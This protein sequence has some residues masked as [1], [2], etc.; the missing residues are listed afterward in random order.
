MKRNKIL[1]SMLICSLV[2]GSVT[3]CGSAARNNGEAESKGGKVKLTA[4]VNKHSLTKDLDEMEWLKE[5][6]EKA[7]VEIEWQQISADWDQKKSAMFASGEIPDLLFNATADA[8]YVQYNG[9]FEDMTP[10]IEKEAPNIQQMF[11]DHPETEIM[12]KT[13]DGKIYGIPGYQAVWPKVSGTMLINKTW[14]DNLNLEMP[15]TWD[16][17]EAVLLAFRDGDPNGNGDTTDEIPMNFMNDFVSRSGGADI[18]NLLGGTGIQLTDRGP[19]G[20]FA[21]DKKVKSSFVDERYK[22]FMK[23]LQKLYGEGC[24]SQEALTQDY[25]KYQS[26]CRNDG[27]TARVGLTFAW[28]SGDRF[29]NELKDE[30]IALPQVKQY[31]DTQ[32]ASYSYD[33]Y[34]L[35]YHGNRVSISSKCK[36]KDAAMR[37]IDGFYDEEASIQV[38][39]GGMNDIDKCIKKNSDG[40]YEVLP[41]ADTALDPGTWK[42]TNAFA[43]NGP[44][45]IRDVMQDKLKLGTDMVGALAEKSVYEG[46]LKNVDPESN[47][48]PQAF[49]KY[50]Q[51]DI[52]TMAMNQA[53]ID[54]IVDQTAAA[55][56][57]DSTRN[58]D[59]E[60]DSYVKSVND[61]GLTQNLEI[62]QTA[63]DEYLKNLK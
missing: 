1:L 21:E 36:D 6:E 52:N 24:I 4:L 3:A 34:G 46:D 29:G 11:Q 57:T 9:L 40:T 54:N 47:L 49:M 42:W 61:A 31:A 44:F 48:Y 51:E 16:E 32:N 14:L 5:L 33:F 28:E 22:D 50:S 59:E 38:L 7:G 10:L 43:D 62:R 27:K 30:Y 20:Y 12:A 60:W 18:L 63:Y 8:D 56:M 2:T 39:F 19:Y 55:W 45:Y 26:V 53:N 25:S 58:I 13:K 37:F 23:F 35:N 41:P 15:T 17:L